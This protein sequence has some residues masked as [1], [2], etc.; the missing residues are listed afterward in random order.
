MSKTIEFHD[1]TLKEVIIDDTMVTI[2]IAKAYIH[3]YGGGFGI[4]KG[5]GWVQT[6]HLMMSGAVVKECPKDLPCDI[7]HGYIIINNGKSDGVMALPSK[8]CGAIEIVFRT[9]TGEKLHV[10]SLSLETR[11]MD[12]A[13]YIEDLP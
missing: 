12:H 4:G 8:T 9:I 11:E 2:C 13:Q 5:E 7:S 6:I 3:V 1:S 10:K